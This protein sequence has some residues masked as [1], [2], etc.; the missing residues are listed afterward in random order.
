VPATGRLYGT[1]AALR[2][3]ATAAVLTD[4]QRATLARWL[5]EQSAEAWATS[6]ASFRR[7][8]GDDHAAAA[9]V[10]PTP[11]A[12]PGDPTPAAAAA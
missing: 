2:H 7:A 10:D 8:L 6:L 9:P 4:A 1:A 5:R 3:A 11:A 12:A